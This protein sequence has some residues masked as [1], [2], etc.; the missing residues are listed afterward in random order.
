MDSPDKPADEIEG[1]S[2]IEEGSR[3]TDGGMGDMDPI[4]EMNRNAL[5]VGAAAAAGL[6][7]ASHGPA[8]NNLMTEEEEESI[9]SH[10]TSTI[11][12]EQRVNFEHEGTRPKDLN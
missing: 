11:L 2:D 10:Q 4:G 1:I 3:I 8:K 7:V 12:D 6:T 5:G 9:H